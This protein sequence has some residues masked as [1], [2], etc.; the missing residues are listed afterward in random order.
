MKKRKW[1]QSIPKWLVL[2][3]IMFGV[4]GV[5]GAQIV[6]AVEPGQVGTGGGTGGVGGP[7]KSDQIFKDKDKDKNNKPAGSTSGG[8]T[9]GT[10]STGTGDVVESTT[11]ADNFTSMLQKLQIPTIISTGYYLGYQNLN[12]GTGDKDKKDKKDKDDGGQAEFD[13]LVTKILNGNGSGGDFSNVGLLYGANGMSSGSGANDIAALK[14]ADMNAIEKN[15][16]N[17]GQPY[18]VFGRAYNSLLSSAKTG[19]AADIDGESFA[20]GMSKTAGAVAKI[21]LNFL[22]AMN[23]APLVLALHDS[24]MLVKSA[25][26]GNVLAAMVAKTPVIAG[27]FGVLG[28]QVPGLGVSY[29]EM[30][31]ASII[32]LNTGLAL[33]MRFFSGAS[34]GTS[35]VHSLRRSLWRIAVVAAVIPMGAYM[36]N[37]LL[38]WM[39]GTTDTPETAMNQNITR[40]NLL[41]GPWAKTTAFGLPSGVTL[42]V[43]DGKFVMNEDTIEKIN[44][45]VAQVSGVIGDESPS[46]GNRKKVAKMIRT[47]AKDNKNRMRFGW[48]NTTLEGDKSKGEWKSDKVIAI[49]QALSDPSSIKDAMKDLDGAFGSDGAGYITQHGLMSSGGNARALT[50]S[51]YQ[52]DGKR[53]GMS[54]IA[55][56]NFANTD[57]DASGW[58]YKSNL[59]GPTIPAVAVSAHLYAGGSSSMADDYAKKFKGKP[60]DAL[61][62]SFGKATVMGTALNALL[63][64]VMLWASFLALV[65]IFTAGLGASLHG[66]MGAALSSTSGAGELIGGLLALIIGVFGLSMLVTFLQSLMNSLFTFVSIILH[67]IFDG[68]LDGFG[69]S[70][71]VDG[72]RKIP[73]GIGDLLAGLFNGLISAIVSIVTIIM[74]P[75]VLRIPINGFASWVT[76]IPQYFAEKAQV[77]ENR[78]TGDYQNHSAPLGHNMSN[79]ARQAAPGLSTQGKVAAA[80]VGMGA[81]LAARGT[82]GLGKKVTSMS[83]S[84]VGGLKE[85]VQ[86]MR[87]KEKGED[88]EGEDTLKDQVDATKQTDEKLDVDRETNE[89]E[90][91]DN[92]DTSDGEH[93][94]DN[95]NVDTNQSEVDT[96]ESVASG[97]GDAADAGDN[98]VDAAQLAAAGA[99]E[100]MGEG[101]G[102]E[103]AEDGEKPAEA[104]DASESA[105][106][107]PAEPT[108]EPNADTSANPQEHQAE[109]G[110][111]DE[112]D[113]VAGDKGD[114]NISNNTEG[115]VDAGQKSADKVDVNGGNVSANES[116]ANESKNEEKKTETENNEGAKNATQ[117]NSQTMASGAKDA[118]GESTAGDKGGKEAGDKAG[119]GDKGNKRS[120]G[121]VNARLKSI[122]KAVAASPGVALKNINGTATGDVSKGE[123]AAA[124]AAHVALSAVGLD[125]VGRKGLE[126]IAKREGRQFAGTSAPQQNQNQDQNKDQNNGQGQSPSQQETQADLQNDINASNPTLNNPQNGD[127]TKTERKSGFIGS[128][129]RKRS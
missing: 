37:S 77:I 102:D 72:I 48:T 83:K 2:F 85:R 52:N 55:A 116:V 50:G 59:S 41:L 51:F 98:G 81:G 17:K 127:D 109:N 10:G 62:A 7:I 71:F 65:R 114:T 54:P 113:S 89:G 34:A 121:A 11:G 110:M 35:L 19:S 70:G 129:R 115:N 80:T 86:S 67:Q 9:G 84:A 20:E 49:A 30:I 107:A 95:T 100:A 4:V 15:F 101:A 90:T 103:N 1:I 29:G 36:Y 12:V 21:G 47:L 28:D 126:N 60:I 75:K 45:H 125:T 32:V 22:Q 124:L 33:I 14:G 46:A 106:D 122:A 40:H 26:E 87:D 94:S 97:D 99:E 91:V 57:F 5:G 123:K 117:M 78:F 68:V 104:P 112:G 92:T 13:G 23:P 8:T 79:A 73:F 69:I 61:T 39:I 43:K 16:G 63:A 31:V 118:S 93:T 119:K 128:I 64:G 53:F 82:W 111:A 6:H 24:R 3:T 66:G 42:T 44:M 74:M 108:A 88:K 56:Y 58:T 38:N 27:A 25:G 18:Y 96:S 120:G 105:A 76:S